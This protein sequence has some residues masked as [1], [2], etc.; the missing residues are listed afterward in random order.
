MFK[1]V[2]SQKIA[3]FAFDT[4]TGVAKTGDAANITAY[5]AKDFGATTVLGDTSA[6]E[7]D[8]TNA[9]G[10]YLFDL[11]QAE[12]NA[13]AL[14]FTG[15]SSTANISIVGQLIYTTPNRFSTIVVDSA[16]LVDATTV[17]LGPSGAATAQTSRDAGA[18][19]D[20]AVSSRMA[21]YSQPAGFL[22][23]TFPTTVASTTNI[24]TVGAVSGA[25][26]SVTAGVSLST[27]AINAIWD[28]LRS[29]H[30]VAGS[31]GESN[32]AIISAAAA[33]GTLSTTQMTTTLTNATDG[34]Y[35]GRTLIWVTGTLVGQA[36]AITN[37]TG[38]SKMLTYS[39]T[40]SAPSAADRFIIV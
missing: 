3:L 30:N 21:S 27:A 33:A 38:A 37:Y 11:A 13:D 31:F 22:S 26:G 20:A 15:K 18:Q 34:F 8:A 32:F 23:A 35:I 25:V 16:G 5:V 14:L 40:T 19:L 24:T 12:T 28:E 1:N 10:W 2:A 7:Q 39:T 4:T 17:K 29:S 9:K 6:T 36:S